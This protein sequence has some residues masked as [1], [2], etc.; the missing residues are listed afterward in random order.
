MSETTAGALERAAQ[1]FGERE[2]V[3]DGALRWTYRELHRRVAA[4]DA[5]L[6]DLGLARGDVVAVLGANSAAHLVAWLAVPRSGRV[7]CELNVRLAPPELA[8]IAADADAR[9]LLVDEAHLDAGLA[10]AAECERIEHVVHLGPG[11]TPPGARSF[12]DLTAGPG[13]APTAVDPEQVAGIFYTGRT[14]GL[15]KG[16]QLTHRN[17]VANAKHALIALGYGAHDSYLHAAPMFHIADANANLA[18]TWVG[19][20]HV[21][22]PAFDPATWLRTVE[23]ERVTQ[24]VLVPA[25]VAAI[26]EDPALADHDL[27]SLAQ[28]AY[29]G[30]PMPE[31]LLLRAMDAI[32]CD[33]CQCYGMTE[34][35]PLVTQLTPAEHR[36]GG[37]LLRSAGRPIVGV[38]A[39]VRRPDG[40]RA[41]PGE[42]GEIWVRGPNVM[43]GYRNRPDE[44]AQALDGDG[45]YRSGDAAYADAGGY[46]H[47]VD[48][49]KDMI[50][51]GGENVYSRE[52][53]NAIHRHPAVLECA[54]FAVPDA[55]WGE[56]VHAA[57]VLRSGARAD[58][59]EIVEHCRALIAGY[60]LPRSIDFHDGPLPKSGAG[61]ILKR[62]LREP[63]WAARERRV[64]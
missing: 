4:L 1:L 12:A 9:A 27:S 25:M 32:A 38:E 64:S 62:A 24:A 22:V 43:A 20:R 57:I 2:A 47:V 33:W 3:V 36:R 13:R 28:I 50:V 53:E 10:L 19:G 41:E 42:T 35:A 46:L 31:E 59:R 7:L 39:E 29:A 40:R 11:A 44:T 56:R 52:V 23:S 26:V 54:V 16:A 34:A 21:I 37:E 15:P 60:K 17:L 6:D 48:R 5:A 58:E 8:F 49:V 63:Y 30:A 61:K 14:T 55:R 45:W 51:S 18:L